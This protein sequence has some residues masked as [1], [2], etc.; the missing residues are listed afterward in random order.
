[1]C[2]FGLFF[3]RESLM[4]LPAAAHAN[5]QIRGQYYAVATTWTI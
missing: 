3:F 5:R 1:M 2:A 4:K